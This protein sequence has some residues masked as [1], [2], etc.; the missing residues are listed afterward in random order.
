MCHALL[1]LPQDM[2]HPDLRIRTLS[3][4][5]IKL[6]YEHV[7]TSLFKVGARSVTTPLCHIYI[8]IYMHFVLSSSLHFVVFNHVLLLLLSF[9]HTVIFV[10]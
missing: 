4:C 5:V 2:G 9:I 8:Y 6:V 10:L 1:V 3:Q 7:C